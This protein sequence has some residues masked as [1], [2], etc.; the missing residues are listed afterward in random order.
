MD[1]N[2][3]YLKINKKGL[4]TV[5]CIWLIYRCPPPVWIQQIYIVPKMEKVLKSIIHEWW[6]ID[7]KNWSLHV[8]TKC[9]LFMMPSTLG[10]LLA[11]YHNTIP[12]YNNYAHIFR[13]ESHNCLIFKSIL[14][15]FNFQ[16]I[17]FGRSFDLQIFN[18][19]LNIHRGSKTSILVSTARPVFKT[20]IF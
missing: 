17:N 5:K 4:K 3:F 7:F 18:I 10:A 2:N 13:N 1:Q 6:I 20:V 14:L 12:P 19:N 9:S 8:P 16:Q 15:T 11:S